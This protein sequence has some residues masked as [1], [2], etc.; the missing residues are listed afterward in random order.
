MTFWII[1]TGIVLAVLALLLLPLAARRSPDDAAAGDGKAVAAYKDQLARLEAE[2]AAGD[3]SKADA[4]AT[5]AEIARRLLA[6]ADDDTQAATHAPA[7][8]TWLAVLAAVAAVAGGAAVYVTTGVPGLRDLPLASRM[9]P[10]N[11]PSQAQMEEQVA[12][13]IAARTMEP[14]AE[15][16]G[17]MAQLNEVLVERPDDPEGHRFLA[18]INRSLGRFQDARA[19]QEKVVELS[20]TDAS[21]EDLANLAELMILAADGYV[22]PEAAQILARTLRQDPTN[23]VARYYSGT[24][25]A[26]SGRAEDALSLW[27][28]ILDETPPD[29]PWRE[30]LSTQIIELARLAELPVPPGVVLEGLDNDQAD[31]IETM[32]EGLA[33]RLAEEGGPAEEWA[34]LIRSLHVLGQTERAEAITAEAQS[35]FAQD[36]DALETIQAVV[37]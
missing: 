1:A 36:P 28:R 13:A 8:A 37:P 30:V 16:A 14:S 32:V 34:R 27:K 26:Q 20:G 4:S 19:A 17:L 24:A 25:L 31:Q 7:P 35:V 12:E 3:I 33:A 9:S 21:T 23:V 22:S 18:S 29:A 5:R 10:A 15:T 11:R 6:A 2:L